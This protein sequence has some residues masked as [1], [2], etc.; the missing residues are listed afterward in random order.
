MKYTTD[1]ARQRAQE[2]GALMFQ[3][4]VGLPNAEL[5]AL[6]NMVRRETLLEAAEYLETYAA[7]DS[8]SYLLS[9]VLRRMAEEE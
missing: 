4:T 6:C 1:Q 2:V 7:P 3:D 5:T 8:A 9:F